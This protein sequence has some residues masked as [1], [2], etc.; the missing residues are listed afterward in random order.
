MSRRTEWVMLIA[1]V[2]SQVAV[3]GLPASGQVGPGGFSGGLSLP[4]RVLHFPPDRSVGEIVL[5][6]GSCVIPEVSQEFHPGY[7]FAPPGQRLGPA[8]GDVRI[9]AGQCVSL[10]LG[11]QGVTRQQCFG[12]L[13]SLAPNDVQ[14]LDFL[15]PLQVDY[16][17]LPYVARLT[18]VTHFCPVTARFSG[19]GWAMLQCLTHL[20]HICTPYGLTDSEMAGIATLQ[21]VNEMEMVATRMTNAGLASIATMRNLQVLHLECTPAV[22]DEGLKALAT[23]QKLR[24]L[25]LAGQFTDRGLAYLAAAPSLK[26]MWLETPRATEQGLRSLAQIQSLER[27]TVPW[28]DQITDQG[29]GYLRSM[30][31]LKALGVGDALSGDAGVASLA[32]LTNLEVLALKG[33]P[34]LTDNALKL[35]AA[36]P[37]LRALEIYHSRITEQG[38]AYLCSC[39][40]LDSIRIVSSI[41]ISQ[42]AIARL[43][44][45]LPNVQ[46]L[47]ISQP[48][49]MAGMSARAA[50]RP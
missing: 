5:V 35:L 34:N 50:Q 47:D 18:G 12:V 39:R 44:T 40:N 13:Q 45:E 17:F 29:I 24:H 16:A 9:P 20:E 4:E 33:G 41:A 27:L 30:P 43:K 48:L 14:D 21:T 49:S 26:V 11:G 6:D 31:K 38:L 28:L 46:T 19:S 42:S 36:M 15:E 37:R 25:R 2:F 22:T 7:V 10:Q 8:R 32:T 3:A 1:A 23:V